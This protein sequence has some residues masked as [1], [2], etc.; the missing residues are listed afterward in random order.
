MQIEFIETL[1]RLG[2]SSYGEAKSKSLNTLYQVLRNSGQSLTFAWTTILSMIMTVAVNNGKAFVPI[3][4]RSAQLICT[5]FVTYLSPDCLALFITTCGCYALQT[6]DLNIAL[7]SINLLMTVADHLTTLPSTRV[8]IDATLSNSSEKRSLSLW[9]AVLAEMKQLG[10]DARSEVRNCAAQTL[11]KTIT[12]H[13]LLLDKDSWSIIIFKV[14]FF[15][16]T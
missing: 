14:F 5:D 12:T 13:G 2:N 16:P 4:F 7:T 6:A 15:T 1:E 8:E 3:G 9:V 10:G 11:F